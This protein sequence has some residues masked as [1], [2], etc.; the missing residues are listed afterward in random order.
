MDNRKASF[1][2]FKRIDSAFKNGDLD[3]LR[4]SIGN[5]DDFPNLTP[6]H[7]AIGC[8]VLQ[9]AIY[10]SPVA[11]IRRLLDIGADPNYDDGDGFP[12]LI[13]AITSGRGDYREIIEALLAAGVDVNQQGFN[14]YTPLHYAASNNDPRL[15]EILLAAGADA[16]LRTRIDD[17]ETPAE[18]A[19]TAGHTQLAE[20]LRRAERR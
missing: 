12:A 7:D 2:A 11:F 15:A 4:Q 9:Y 6:P 1:E 18:V 3:A 17:C 13:A 8:S 10:H 14:D 16:A 19:E 20:M 5:L